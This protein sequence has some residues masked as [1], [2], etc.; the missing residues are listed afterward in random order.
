MAQRIWSTILWTVAFFVY[1]ITALT[2]LYIA[3]MLEVAQITGR[4]VGPNVFAQWAHIVHLGKYLH[5]QIMKFTHTEK[6]Y[7]HR[8]GL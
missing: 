3:L 7:S 1:N 4:I 2:G 8:G 5:N 6:L